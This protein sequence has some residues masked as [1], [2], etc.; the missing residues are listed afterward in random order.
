MGYFMKEDNVVFVF[1]EN[2]EDIESKVLKIFKEYII[3]QGI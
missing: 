3:L 1:D 2:A